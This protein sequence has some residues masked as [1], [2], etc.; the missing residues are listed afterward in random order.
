M[1]SISYDFH[2]H[3]SLSPCADDDM[4]PNNIVNMSIL[5]NL[6]AIAVTDHNSCENAKAVMECAKGTNLIVIPGMEVESSEEV[7][8]VCLFK[9]IDEALIFNEIIKN[10]LPNIKNKEEIFGRQL[11]MDKNDEIIGIKENLLST[12]TLLSVNQI[13]DEVKKIGGV[14][15]PSHIDKQAYSIISN[16][17]FIPP[18]LNFKT[19]EIKMKEKKEQMLLK[20]NISGYKIIHNSDAHYLGDIS[21]RENFIHVDKKDIQSII[22]IL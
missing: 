12:A 21:E 15:F 11:L 22:S 1:Q 18:E 17:G 19:V 9:N 4:T 16:L 14:C 7:H 10:N 8:M 13:F 3:T 2:I 5:K 20:H 6:D